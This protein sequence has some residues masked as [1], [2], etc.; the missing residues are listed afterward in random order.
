MTSVARQSA[1][2]AEWLER[3]GKYNVNSEHDLLILTSVDIKRIRKIA[4]EDGF[5]FPND[6]DVDLAQISLGGFFN[7]P[8]EQSI[9][10]CCCKADSSRLQH[11]SVKAASATAVDMT[12]GRIIRQF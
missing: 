3:K 7:I 12:C 1:S 5:A 9:C 10:C 4:S 2:H 11:H 8:C 6:E